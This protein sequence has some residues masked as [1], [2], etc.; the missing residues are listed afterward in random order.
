[1]SDQPLTLTGYLAYL[2]HERNYSPHT[3][4]N[5]ARDIRRLFEL[6][7]STALGELKSHH[8][9]RYIAQLHGS[10]LSGRSLARLLSSW[11]GFYNYLMRDHGCPGN[12]CVGLRAPKSPKT[13]PHAL[14]P[15][16]AVQLVEMKV[17]TA[18]DTRDKAMFELLYSSGL[19]L[20]ELISLDLST[21][22]DT[23]HSNEV[24]VTG[25]GSKTRVVPVGQAA[26]A[27]LKAWMQ[28]R[29]QVAKQDEVALFVGTRGARISPRS[30][31]MQL[32]KWAVK[33]GL[34]RKVYPHMLRHSFATHVLQS[35]GDLRAV[36]E[37]L[38]HASISTTQVYTHLDFQYL[39]KIYDSAHPRAKKKG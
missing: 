39:A 9:R 38:G 26:I 31:E 34:N 32:Q 22:Q 5:Y 10:G 28:V 13:L 30:V 19:R 36:Q 12:P 16:E 37:M 14:S 11:R 21:M 8:I 33:Q 24:R 6:A 3:S 7:G 15:D 25:K 4:E 1:M 20:A 27:A 29:E 23:L 2:Q 35:S 17:E 18:L